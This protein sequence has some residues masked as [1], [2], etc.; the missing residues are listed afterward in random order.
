M[1]KLIKSVSLITIVFILIA[2]NSCT[3]DE[4]I[5]NDNNTAIKR[6]KWNPGENASF[7][8]PDNMLPFQYAVYRNNE[9]ILFQHIQLRLDAIENIGNGEGKGYFILSLSPDAAFVYYGFISETSRYYN[10][11]IW[12]FPD[13]PI[14]PDNGGDGNMCFGWVSVG[15]HLSDNFEDTQA[16]AHE[17]MEKGYTVTINKNKKT[18]KYLAI[19]QKWVDD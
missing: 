1:N 3:K 8:L 19:A 13:D 2:A 6:Q 17:Q 14:D 11:T 4:L 10:P 9:N 5:S 18:G 16:W 12:I 15:K 7:I